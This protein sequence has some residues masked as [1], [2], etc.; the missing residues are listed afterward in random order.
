MQN[1]VSMAVTIGDSE[2]RSGSHDEGRWR[3]TS[4]GGAGLD[5]S[6]FRDKQSLKVAVV[7]GYSRRGTLSVGGNSVEL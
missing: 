1:R 3:S 2:G 5:Q 6:V 4:P 7:F